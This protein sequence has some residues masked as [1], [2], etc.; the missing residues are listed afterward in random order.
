MKPIFIVLEG[1]DG[2]GTSTQA[3]LL[4]NH[5]QRVNT[6]VEVTAEPS[7][8]LIGSTIRLALKRRVK[9]QDDHK[10]FDRQMALMF[11][12]DRHDHLYNDVEGI[13][14][15]LKKGT[16]V[17]CTRYIPSSFAYHCSNETEWDFISKINSEFPL[18]DLLIYL[19]NHVESSL[20]RISNR[21]TLDQYEQEGKLK[22][23]YA[24]Y[25]R[26][27]SEYRGRSTIID[28]SLPKEEI[29]SKIIDIIKNLN[30]PKD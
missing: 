24:N 27:L 7:A 23:A 20:K 10:L 16:N 3:Q 11:A 6:P 13:I 5:F 17:I 9:F 26:Y 19:D 8:G 22:Q 1:L 30:N 21:N 28:A 18:P 12:A 4:A 29:F 15:T 25:K 14:P 2:S